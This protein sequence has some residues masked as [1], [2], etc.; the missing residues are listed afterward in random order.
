MTTGTEPGGTAGERAR[1]AIHA[2]RLTDPL[3]AIGQR[4]PGPRIEREART[5]RAMFAGAMATFVAA[6]GLVAMTAPP[7]EP[8]PAPIAAPSGNPVIAFEPR[9]EVF[10][11]AE[12]AAETR[13]KEKRARKERPAYARTRSS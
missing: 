8:A 1:K 4:H 2:R 10:V 13:T 7:S 5:R 12:A 3:G 6:F 9:Q 11:P